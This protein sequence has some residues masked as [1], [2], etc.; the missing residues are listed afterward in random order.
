M[1][2]AALSTVSSRLSVV[3]PIIFSIFIYHENPNYK[4]VIGFVFTFLTI[5]FFYFS[6]KELPRGHLRLIDY[7]YLFALL[8]GI[9]FADFSVKIFQQWRPITE[10]SFF[11]FSIFTFSCIYVSGFILVK[12]IKFEKDT[13]IRGG[14]LGIPNIFST[15][16]L[17]GALTKLPAILV[18]PIT[19]IGIILLTMFGAALIWNEKLN[20][21]GKYALFLGIISI[22]LLG[23]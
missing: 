6:L 10:K 16:F 9:G 5:L 2:G 8:P 13:L 1:A 18:Y 12:R 23:L 3:V 4:Q 14:I 15:Y 20:V 17:L 21:F 11:L 7:L 19:N 22:V